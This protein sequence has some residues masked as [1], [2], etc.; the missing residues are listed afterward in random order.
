MAHQPVSS[1]HYALSDA[2]IGFQHGCPAQRQSSNAEIATM[3]VEWMWQ[4]Q[5]PEALRQELTY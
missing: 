1:P 2:G 4:L 5:R 3:K